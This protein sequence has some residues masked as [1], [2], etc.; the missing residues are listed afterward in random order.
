MGAGRGVLET[1]DLQTAWRLTTAW[2]GCTSLILFVEGLDPIWGARTVPVRLTFL[3]LKYV[4]N[5]VKRSIMADVAIVASEKTVS[6]FE[7]PH[8][9]PAL[10]RVLRLSLV[11]F[12]GFDWAPLQCAYQIKWI[13]GEKYTYSI[14]H[15]N[16]SST[17]CLTSSLAVGT[18]ALQYIYSQRYTSRI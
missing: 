13:N 10:L 15:R 16:W 4:R 9:E 12:Y 8:P 6:S 17:F 3:A 2:N 18:V 1:L 14:Q 5:T 7:Y 11:P